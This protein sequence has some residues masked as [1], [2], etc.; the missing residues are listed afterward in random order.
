VLKDILDGADSGTF[1]VPG[2]QRLS[3][4]ARWI[5][6]SRRRRGGIVVDG[7]CRTAVLKKGKSILPIG[8][9]EIRG[10]FSRGDSITVYDPDGKEI[11][12]GLSNYDS[13]AFKT[14]MGRKFKE[15]IV[16]HDNFVSTQ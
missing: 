16:H 4:K 14:V 1:F 12:T 3:R 10:T 15:E 5:A 2:E 8:V 11:G 7:G 6:H 13:E 9:V